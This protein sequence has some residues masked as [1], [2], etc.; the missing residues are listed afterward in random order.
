MAEVKAMML[1][2]LFVRQIGW[3]AKE[4]IKISVEIPLAS[5]FLEGACEGREAGMTVGECRVESASNMFALVHSLL[6]K[7]KS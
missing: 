6:W 3:L 2:L 1:L 4:V 7:T 5:N